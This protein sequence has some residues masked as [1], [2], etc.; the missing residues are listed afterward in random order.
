MDPQQAYVSEILSLLAN[1]DTDN[2]TNNGKNDEEQDE[3]DPS[4]PTR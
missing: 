4:F 3:A 1:G 2:N